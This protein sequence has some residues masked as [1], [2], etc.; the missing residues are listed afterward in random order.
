MLKQEY[1]MKEENFTVQ[2]IPSGP[3]FSA[4]ATNLKLHSRIILL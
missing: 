4:R 3:Q 1:N 2:H